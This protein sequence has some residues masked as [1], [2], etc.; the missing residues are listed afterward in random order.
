MASSGENHPSVHCRGA[1]FA[2]STRLDPHGVGYALQHVPKANLVFICD[3]T[4]QMY[5][6]G[7]GLF[8]VVLV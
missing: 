8:L 7:F 3:E 1:P 6:M 4:R 2:S 5:A